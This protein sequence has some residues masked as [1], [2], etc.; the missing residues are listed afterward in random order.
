MTIAIFMQVGDGVV[1][2][3][4]SSST[5]F[6]QSQNGKT[7]VVKVYNYA[8]KIFQFKD[9]PIGLMMWG[10]G[11]IGPHSVDSLLSYYGDNYPSINQTT[12]YTVQKMAQDVSD[13]ILKQFKKN[14]P[15][16]ESKDWPPLGIVVAGYSS[17]NLAPE[18][19]LLQFPNS[20]T[21]KPMRQDCG[22]N[23]YGQTEPIVRIV[24]GYSLKVA[25]ILIQANLLPEQQNIVAQL[26]SAL[27]K[28]Q[29]P[30]IFDSMPLQDAVDLAIWLVAIAKGYYRFIIGAPT[31]GGPTDVAIIKR[32]C[33]KWVQKKELRGEEI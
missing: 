24:M 17:Q 10:A 5:I 21:P 15:N 33:F 16:L 23:W 31:V 28:L 27:G 20:L 22:V 18:N 6:G 11:N 8:H 13:F 32:N 30:I 2:A 12:S 7:G 14:L 26:Q 1:L 4:D 25:N 19:Y 3:A 29:M 9:Y